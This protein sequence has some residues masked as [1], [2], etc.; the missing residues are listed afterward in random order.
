[1]DLLY[2]R[3]MMMYVDKTFTVGNGRQVHFSQGNLWYKATTNTWKF[4]DNQWDVCAQNNANI[5]STYKGYID[6][7]GY[8]SSGEITGH[9]PYQHTQNPDDYCKHDLSVS[10]DWGNVCSSAETDSLVHNWRTLSYSEWRFL[11]YARNTQNGYRFVKCTLW[12]NMQGM[13]IFPDDFNTNISIPTLNLDNGQYS[14][15]VISSEQTFHNEFEVK[16]CVFLPTSGYRDG[17]TVLSVYARG[18]YWTSSYN[19][20]NDI[21]HLLGIDAGGIIIGTYKPDMNFTAVGRNTYMGCAVR[22]VYDC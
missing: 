2:R 3:R 17:T 1:M 18:Y 11:L 20:D 21:A 12:N 15:F 4:A 9:E 8:G 14:S 6:L 7:F 13:I 10:C 5:S 16:G 22:L 19:K